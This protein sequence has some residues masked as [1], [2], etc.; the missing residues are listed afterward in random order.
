MFYVYLLKSINFPDQK[1]VGFT[2]N[3]EDRLTAHNSDRSIHTAKY[4]PWILH[5]HFAFSEK[6]L[7]LTF[8]LYLKSHAGRAFAEKRLWQKEQE[9]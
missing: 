5:A 4:K 9:T 7:A 8:E 2:I 6:N 1:H 3:V